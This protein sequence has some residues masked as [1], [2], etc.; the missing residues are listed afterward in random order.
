MPDCV[1]RNA[2]SFSHFRDGQQ[3]AFPEPLESALQSISLSNIADR[4]GCHCQAV[5]CPKA[6]FIQDSG[7]VGV[8]AVVQEAVHFRYHGRI[9]SVAFAKA[10]RSWQHQPFGRATAE[11]DIELNLLAL[12][13]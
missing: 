5:A 2:A 10:Q 13:D 3:A 4:E 8:I 7:G 9:L 12:T 1:Y 11:P 6:F